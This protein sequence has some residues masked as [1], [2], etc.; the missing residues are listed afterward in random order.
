[1]TVPG[2]IADPQWRAP[3]IAGLASVP[4]TLVLQ[5]R[6]A[7]SYVFVPVLF[8]GLVVGYLFAERPASSR[9]AGMQAGLVGG[10]ALLGGGVR[11]LTDIPEYS[12]PI[13]L[14]VLAGLYTAL[15]V[16]L[17]IGYFGLVGGIGGLV[18]GWLANRIGGSRSEPVAR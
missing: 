17:Y 16:V 8:A 4:V 3:I 14:S 7:G 12:F 13:G 9:R 5:W 1:M 18:G 15:V 2:A 11:F 6:S 10:L